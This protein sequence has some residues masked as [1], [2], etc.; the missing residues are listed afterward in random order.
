MV[1]LMHLIH[2]EVVEVLHQLAIM[3]VLEE[4][5]LLKE[6]ALRLVGKRSGSGGGGGG[7]SGDNKKRCDCGSGFVMVIYPNT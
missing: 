1:V 6:V 2:P 7:E 4:G 5:E 3:Q